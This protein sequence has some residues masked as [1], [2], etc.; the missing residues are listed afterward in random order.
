MVATLGGQ[1]QV[2]TFALDALLARGEAISRVVLLHMA[3]EEERLQAAL[4][5]L[6]D[7]FSDGQYQG[8][9]CKVRQVPLS[10]GNAP[11]TGI[12]NETD[13]DA[14][15]LAVRNLLSELKA[16]GDELHICVS[17]GRRMVALLATSAAALLCD[18][19]DHL[20]HMYTPSEFEQQARGG[21]ILHAQPEDG[22][23]LIEVPLVPWGA[24]FPGLRAMAQAP[25]EAVA[26]QMGWLRSSERQCEQ[27]YA[28]LTAR[29]RD[30]L[31]AFAQGEAPQDVAELLNISMATVN[32]H[33]T[34]I[35]DECRIAWNF[36]LDERL[37]YHFLREKFGPFVG[38]LG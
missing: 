7:E 36:A 1:P 10:S 33:K 24:Y 12:R 16:E 5:T 8:Q 17:G 30:V 22:V 6:L 28:R 18:H 21:A 29:Q 23:Q 27:V 15:W 14:T 4:R 25:Q 9:P 2:V 37:D 11:L 34:T 19:R 32:T 38:R 26:A 31:I 3:A 20:W 35:L 13:A